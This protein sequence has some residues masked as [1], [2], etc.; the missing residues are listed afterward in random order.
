[1][2]LKN[3]REVPEM[4]T[5]PFHFSRRL[6]VDGDDFMEVPI[7]NISASSRVTKSL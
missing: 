2:E 6:Y 3:N 1:M 7:R 4:G 5:E